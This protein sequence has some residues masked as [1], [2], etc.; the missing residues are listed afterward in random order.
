MAKIANRRP[1]T[2]PDKAKVLAYLT[3]ALPEWDWNVTSSSAQHVD[4]EGLPKGMGASQGVGD[5]RARNR[6]T[7]RVQFCL[8]RS[9]AA[10]GRDHG[11]QSVVSEDVD[12]PVGPLLH[13]ML[14][15]R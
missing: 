9:G 10:R 15:R 6:A 11:G 8:S 7:L 12:Q 13:R 2:T 1:P 3:D 4:V 14:E 5:D